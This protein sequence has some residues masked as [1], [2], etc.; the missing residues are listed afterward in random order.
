MPLQVQIPLTLRVGISS[1]SYNTTYSYV[2]DMI[3]VAD[4]VDYNSSM[5][6]L[7]WPQ[8]YLVGVANDTWNDVLPTYNNSW[9][10]DHAVPLPLGAAFS[11]PL[12]KVA[13]SKWPSR[14]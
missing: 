14:S 5:P 7:D 13:Q 11:A 6:K 1:G 9:I 10:G 2:P 3:F 12:L 8:P 4:L